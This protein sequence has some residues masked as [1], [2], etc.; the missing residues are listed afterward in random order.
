MRQLPTIG[1]NFHSNGEKVEETED[2]KWVF[3]VDHILESK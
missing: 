1:G 2:I 3:I